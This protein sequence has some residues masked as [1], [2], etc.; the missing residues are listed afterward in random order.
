[1]DIRAILTA[2]LKNMS[3]VDFLINE[4]SLKTEEIIK[5]FRKVKRQDFVLPEDREMAEMDIPLPIDHGQTISQ[6]T[7][8][9][10]TIELL[11]P[12]KGEKVMDIGSGSGWTTA[13][14]AEI[15]GEDGKVF[16][17]ELLQELKEFGEENVSK[18]NYISK[19][20]AE[21]IQADGYKGLID[22]APFDR[23]LISAAAEKVPKELLKQL[24]VGGVL[25][26]PVGRPYEIQD[27]V[28]IERIGEDEFKET[29]YPGFIFVPLVKT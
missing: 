4:G 2:H 13:I 21:M 20:I 27:I 25:V 6:P 29:R 14:L 24:R 8:V 19:G 15:V 28:R 22:E 18:Y 7:T 10:F 16:G 17:I 3:I 11:G 23:I 12:Q 26:I 1:M 5:A 9:A